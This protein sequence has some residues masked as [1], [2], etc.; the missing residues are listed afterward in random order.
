VISVPRINVGRVI[1]SPNMVQTFV[2]YRQIGEFVAGRWT[3]TSL[4]AINVK[5]IAS[6]EGTKD[7]IQEP[8]ADRTSQLM[9]FYT[10]EQVFVTHASPK[11]GAS[12]RIF[13]KGAYYRVFKVL[14]WSS[15]GYYKSYAI[16]MEGD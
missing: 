8:E 6:A 11:A 9:C 10:K 14:P 13:Y 16:S 2:I 7:I 15:Y 5:G 12:D 1:K 4:K 3:Q